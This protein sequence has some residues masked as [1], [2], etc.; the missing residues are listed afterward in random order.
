[1]SAQDRA[2]DPKRKPEL[3]D[4]YGKRGGYKRSLEHTGPETNDVM[5]DFVTDPSYSRVIR[6]GSDVQNPNPPKKRRY[7]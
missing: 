4:A 3:F 5:M 6:S 1:M 2:N 7:K